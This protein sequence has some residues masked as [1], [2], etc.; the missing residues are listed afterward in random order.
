[1]EASD[2]PTRERAH[3]DARSTNHRRRHSSLRWLPALIFVNVFLAL[4]VIGLAVQMRVISNDRS[5]LVAMEGQMSERIVAQREE[6]A[7]LRQ[8]MALLVEG[9][10]PRLRPIVLDEVVHLNQDYVRQVLFTVTRKQGVGNYEYT[11]VMENNAFRQ[12]DPYVKIMFF[13]RNGIQVG[14]SEIGRDS[15]GRQN[16]DILRR[17][18]VRSHYSSV[19]L[20]DESSPVYFLVLVD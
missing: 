16:L 15:S 19:D 11:L 4:T 5:F 12:I 8:E 17:G 9:R 14:I 20:F 1:M 3:R 6:I 7:S 10:M 2:R 18:E 13:D